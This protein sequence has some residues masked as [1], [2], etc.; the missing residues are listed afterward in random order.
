MTRKNINLCEIDFKFKKKCKKYKLYKSV[1][2]NY[3]TIEKMS[4]ISEPCL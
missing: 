2:L 4:L 1:I 3:D